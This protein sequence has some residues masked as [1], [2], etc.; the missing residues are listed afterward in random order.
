[1]KFADD[2]FRLF[3]GIIDPFAPR[4]D[5]E[6]PNKLLA[7]VWHYVGQARWAFA[8]MLIY[9]FLNAIVET[10]IFTFIGDIVD[11]LGNFQSSQSFSGGWD[12][13]LSEYGSTL[14][15]MLFVVVVFRAAVITFG[16]L[17]EEQVIVAGF[18]TL[19]RWQSHKH[20]I[21]QSL[22]FFQNDLAGRISQKVFQSG[23]A[24]G[25][26]MI[27]LFQVIWFIGVFSITAAGMLSALNWRL[28]AIV[29]LWMVVFGLLARKYVP[30][31]RDRGREIAE[32]ASVA[33]GQMV[34]GYANIQTIKLYGNNDPDRD[35]IYEG[36]LGT[37]EA[38]KTFTRVLTSVRVL[39]SFINGIAISA[40]TWVAIDFWLAGGMSIGEVAFA[41]A[42]VIRLHMMLNRLMG[43]LNGFFRSVGTTQNTMDMVAQPLGLVDDKN[44]PDLVL[45]KG[46]IKLKH[47]H[48]RHEKDSTLL[49]DLSM[50]IKPGEKIGIVGPSGAGKTT[51]VNLILRFFDVNEG[52]ISIDGQ[53]IAHVTQD[54]LRSHFSLVQQESALFH[55]SVHDNIAYGSP[56]ATREDVVKAAKR[57]SAHEFIKDLHD[58]AGRTG[59][60]SQVGER[61]VK[62][63]GGQRQRIAIARIFLRDAPIL[64]LDEATSALDSE[65]EAAVQENL[66]EL[67]KGKTVIAIA[68]RL[69]TIASF[70]R[71]IILDKGRVVDEGTHKQLLKKG[72]LY[73]DLWERQSGGFIGN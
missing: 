70:D 42:L 7:Y 38:L 20:V 43:N 63:S 17:I 46:H 30:M 73:A 41:L 28:G 37:F 1:M 10:A 21:A 26:M 61:G 32:A 31:I 9:G 16:A 52:E 55:R 35:W 67:M 71:L 62:L 8:A 66:F 12:S 6:P 45:K 69:S 24:T 49:E 15:F 2:I 72:G 39:L 4:K 40:V 48:F 44:A 14:I 19:M 22:T 18:F 60:E 25:E 57:A 47:I 59:Y 36:V 33:S 27:S 53:N 51:L 29:L 23:Q 34:D 54:S 13:L 64:I 65:I 68:H 56:N 5:Y 58:Q 50:E 3:E 11:I